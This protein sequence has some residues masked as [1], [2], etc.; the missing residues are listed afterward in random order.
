L[1]CSDDSARQRPR[2]RN[3]VLLTPN[4][5]DSCCTFP[6]AHP[7]TSEAWP[8]ETASALL[9]EHGRLRNFDPRLGEGEI[10][11][12]FTERAVAAGLFEDADAAEMET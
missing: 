6:V 7:A 9:G 3:P 8:S 5:D 11:E 1:L 4:A 2:L 10:S 12:T